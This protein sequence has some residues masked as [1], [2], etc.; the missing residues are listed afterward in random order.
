MISHCLRRELCLKHWNISCVWIT[1]FFSAIALAMVVKM[2][3]YVWA[4]NA[5]ANSANLLYCPSMVVKYLLFFALNPKSRIEESFIKM[6]NESMNILI[7]A[8]LSLIFNASNCLLSSLRSNCVSANILKILS[9]WLKF[10]WVNWFN[11]YSSISF[12]MY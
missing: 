5:N 10:N 7:Y 1:S 8:Q 6:I 2:Y 4:I 11:F 12:G 3:G 9:S